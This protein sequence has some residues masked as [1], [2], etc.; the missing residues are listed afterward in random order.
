VAA[1]AGQPPCPHR[2]GERAAQ[3]A[4]SRGEGAGRGG[5]GRAKGRG[6]EPCGGEELLGHGTPAQDAKGREGESRPRGSGGCARWAA[7]QAQRGQGRTTGQKAGRE[8]REGFLVVFPI[9]YL[10]LNS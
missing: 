8:W 6:N 10:I 4:E 9:F 3:Q 7:P 2:P 5:L 1:A